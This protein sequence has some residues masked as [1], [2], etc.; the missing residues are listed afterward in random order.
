MVPELRVDVLPDQRL[1]NQRD[2]GF[3]VKRPR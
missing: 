1:G 2:N 3:N